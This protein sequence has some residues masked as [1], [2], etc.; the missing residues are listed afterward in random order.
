ML[1]VDVKKSAIDLF[2]FIFLLLILYP[3]I[4]LHFGSNLFFVLCSPPIGK[5]SCLRVMAVLALIFML[6]HTTFIFLSLQY[7]PGLAVLC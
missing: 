3:E 7:W 5:R 2:L 4:L 6:C 1:A